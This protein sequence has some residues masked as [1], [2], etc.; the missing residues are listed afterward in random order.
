M[1]VKRHSY[2][3]FVTQGN[4]IDP[5]RAACLRLPGMMRIVRGGR[6][7]QPPEAPSLG[8]FGGTVGIVTVR[9]SV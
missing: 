7:C 2:E 8:S 5:A 3:T 1:K 9:S 6:V 4:N